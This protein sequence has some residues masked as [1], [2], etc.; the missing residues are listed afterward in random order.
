[1]RAARMNAIRDAIDSGSAA[2]YLRIYSGTRPA[3]TGTPS[4][5]ILAELRFQDP[6]AP[7]STDGNLT[8]SALSPALQATNSGTAS[9]FRVLNSSNVVVMDGSIGQYE[10]MSVSN[11]NIVAQQ[12]VNCTAFNIS[13]GNQS[14]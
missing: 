8:M 4:G 1:M 12:Q 13:D 11:A 9:W 3:I 10:D 6:C 5:L 14:F 7:A 2:G